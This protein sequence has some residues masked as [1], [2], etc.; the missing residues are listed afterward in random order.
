MKTRLVVL[1]LI[2]L[3]AAWAA[4]S[5]LAASGA[6]ARRD[7]RRAA[8]LEARVLAARRSLP[9]TQTAP[10]KALLQ[11]LAARQGIR[12][13]FLAETEREVAGGGRERQVSA[14]LVRVPQASL[15][16]LLSGLEAPGTALRVRE[17]RLRPSPEEA[18]LYE[19][20]ELVAVG[21]AAKGGAR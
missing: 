4:D 16:R 18:G 19:E 9:S 14:R 6:R 8:F 1:L 3:P 12:V 11:D 2:A 15:V 20:A 5:G 21:P 13:A 10:P 17:L 7:E